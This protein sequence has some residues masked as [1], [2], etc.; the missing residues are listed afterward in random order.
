MAN[1]AEL[2]GIV[3]AN[4]EGRAQLIASR[5]RIIAAGDEARRES[6]ATCTTARRLAWRARCCA[7]KLAR[8]E[9]GDANGPAVELMDEA[10]TLAEAASSELR[11]LSHG[12][13]PGRSPAAGWPPG[14]RR[15][16]RAPAFR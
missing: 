2:V 9:P 15:S 6:S 16:S 7:L 4:A 1:F 14:S 10:L 8:R 5:A 3:I 12:V 11:E 13:L